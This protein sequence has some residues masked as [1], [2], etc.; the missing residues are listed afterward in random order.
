[1]K[2]SLPSICYRN[3]ELKKI[4]AA[5]LYGSF[6]S[7][8]Y[9]A[10]FHEYDFTQV[11]ITK[12]V[13]IIYSHGRANRR[14]YDDIINT[15]YST[16]TSD[17]A[18]L[19]V[20]KLKFSFKDKLLFIKSLISSLK[21]FYGFTGTFSMKIKVCFLLARAK[22]NVDYIEKIFKC[23]EFKVL[24]TFC[25]ALGVDNALSQVANK[26]GA[27]T[28]TLQHGQYHMVNKDIPEN[29]ALQ[30][31]TS[32]YL[33]SWG[34]ATQ[35]EFNLKCP[36]DSEVVPLGICSSEYMKAIPY[37][38]DMVATTAKKKII[39]IMFN[40]DNCSD[41]NVKMILLVSQFC[42]H[43]KLQFTVQFHPKNRRTIY[44]TILNRQLCYIPNVNQQ[45][46]GLSIV[47]T[48]G[49]LVKLL[50]K[51]KLFFL[52]KDSMTP[53]LFERKIPSFN[54][55]KE[56]SMQY[57]SLISDPLT[58]SIKMAVAQSYFIAD[59]NALE[60]Y[61]SFTQKLVGKYHAT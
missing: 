45:K 2:Y 35:D 9:T 27:I 16:L 58:F 11:K 44:Q 41:Q 21:Y 24:A 26:H 14:D 10:L 12:D 19:S 18:T 22:L 43:S 25:D 40:A 60:N 29:L 52:F 46:I 51:G 56:I 50:A 49:V 4:I 3:I 59:G 38:N 5:P 23:S 17:I 32:H 61:R 15:Y 13:V 42:Q 33:L 57:N 20:L 48:S 7:T 31:L 34:K 54:N 39:N 47:Y 37:E 8:L 6:L 30:N 36:S 53:D 1:M 28:V 55:L